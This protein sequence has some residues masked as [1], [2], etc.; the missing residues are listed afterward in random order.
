MRKPIIGITCDFDIVP[1]KKK[2]MK[3]RERFSLTRAYVQAV[4]EAGGVPVLLAGGGDGAGTRQQLARLGGLLLTG[5]MDHNPKL[6]GQ[7][8]H[9]KTDM[10]P[11]VRQ[12]YEIEIAKLAMKTELPILGICLGCQTLNII[13]GGTLI[14]DVASLVKTKIIHRQKENRDVETHEVQVDKSSRLFQIFGKEKVRANSFHH[15]ALG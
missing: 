7:K 9:P 12:E 8:K 6:Y 13:N 2:G 4:I 3:P 5:G 1:P 11:S 10:L 15:Q 14:Q